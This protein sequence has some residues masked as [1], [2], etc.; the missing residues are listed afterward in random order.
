[1][2]DVRQAQL[3][4]CCC[5]TINC[6]RHFTWSR[7]SS[8]DLAEAGGEED[9]LEARWG[10]GLTTSLLVVCVVCIVLVS[11]S[12]VAIIIHNIKARSGRFDLAGFFFEGMYEFVLETLVTHR[13][14]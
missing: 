11:L 7:H 8:P 10:S 2:E 6:N 13:P 1:M 14:E 3:L 12:T 4:F 5:N 9:L